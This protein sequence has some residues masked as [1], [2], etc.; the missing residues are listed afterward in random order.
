MSDTNPSSARP[1]EAAPGP[2]GLPFLGS[3]LEN[4]RDFFAFRDRVAA[5]HGGVARYEIL[6]QDV[7]LLTD[8]DAI[9]RVLVTENERYVKGELFQQQLRPVLGNGLLNSEGDFWRRQRHLIQPAFTPDRIAG[10]ADMMVGVTERTSGR[11]R[12]GEVRDVH[13]DMMG[14]TLDIVARALMGVDIRDRTPAIGGA[15]DTVMEQSAGG[16]LLDL[17]PPSVPTPGREKLREAV[18]SLDRIV[19]ELVEEKRRALRDGEI[20]PDAD[21]VSALLTAEDDDGERMAAEQVRDE[22]KTLLLA[23]HETTALS[24]TFT[25][26]LLARHPEIEQRLLD[27]LETELGDEPAGFD[28]VR[29]L[30]YLDKVVTE[31]M[32]LLPPVHGILREPTE[33][34]ELGGY[35]VPEGTPLAIS[36]WIVHRDSDHYDDPLAFRPERWTDDMERELHPLAYFPFSS[37]P[38]RCVG[39]RFALL[40]AKLILATLLRRFAFEVVDPVDLEAN[41]EASITTRPTGPVR[42]RLHER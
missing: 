16:S 36:Q 32:R 19:D 10:Y 14:L 20:G 41:L 18:A 39:D 29:D 31:S 2:D 22:V 12:D 33:D 23:G 13:R 38:R 4:R 28:T 3:F 25:L 17:L 11:W 30:K 5:E 1:P 6:G 24:L 26:H 8:P 7:F 42:M 9:R 40:E 15:L 35:R 27:E 34:V 37:G 21:V